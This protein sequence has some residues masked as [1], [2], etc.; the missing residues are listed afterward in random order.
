MIDFFLCPM[1]M[2]H[3]HYESEHRCGKWNM[4][5]DHRTIHLRLPEA[6]Q[7]KQKRRTHR[8][9]REVRDPSE[10]GERSEG[11]MGN[12]GPSD[13][14]KLD[15]WFAEIASTMKEK[16]PRRRIAQDPRIKDLVRR[17]MEM[18]RSRDPRARNALTQE[19]RKIIRIDTRNK[20]NEAIKEAFARNT[21]WAKTANELRIN[22]TLA[23]PVFCI[24][25][26]TTTSDKEA[27]EAI[28][29]HI[30]R[31][32]KEPDLPITIPPWNQNHGI[33]T[34]SLEK[35][36]GQAVMSAKKGKASDASGLSNACIKSLREG[37]INH[38]AKVIR[39]NGE[40]Q[41]GHPLKWKKIP[42]TS[43]PQKRRQEPA[44]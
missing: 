18:P 16:I 39:Q 29:E 34:G 11:A 31:I 36:V 19:I 10:F 21:N 28:A 4:H 27:I 15:E 42:G 20:K 30:E 25:G 26:K 8:K 12:T 9:K 32:Y 13:M 22:R 37:T 17:R 44:L 3:W 40:N 6:T 33:E 43:S 5:S 1:H 24:E 7:Q 38:I 35:A 2:L 41:D 23:A 14:H